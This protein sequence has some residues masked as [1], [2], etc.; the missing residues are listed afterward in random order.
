VLTRLLDAMTL[1]TCEGETVLV[2]QGS[3]DDPA[4]YVV[5]HGTVGMY[6]EPAPPTHT[7]ARANGGTGGL[8]DT[9]AGGDVVILV[10]AGVRENMCASA[11]V[12][13]SV[14]ARGCECGFRNKCVPHTLLHTHSHLHTFTLTRTHSHYCTQGSTRTGGELLPTQ[15]RARVERWGEQVATLEAVGVC[16][17]V[18]IYI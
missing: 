11:R 15:E 2:Q 3:T 8:D 9:Y 5:L 1:L 16:V 12:C 7:R 4:M 10:C 13:M 18:Y 17:C 14:E 6:N